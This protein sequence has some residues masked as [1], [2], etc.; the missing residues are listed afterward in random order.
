MFWQW[1]SIAAQ[2]YWHWLCRLLGTASDTVLVAGNQNGTQDIAQYTKAMNLFEHDCVSPFS[3]SPDSFITLCT[4][5]PADRSVGC[6]VSIQ[7]VEAEKSEALTA[8]Q[9]ISFW[10]S[11]ILQEQWWTMCH[12]HTSRC[13]H[14]SCHCS[15]SDCN[16]WQEGVNIKSNSKKHYLKAT[17]T[18]KS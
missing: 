7:K 6:R 12:G 9:K 8:L 10:G 18:D 15:C 13:W 17:C 4:W 16:W 14:I 1:L 2:R 3:D 11:K 5:M